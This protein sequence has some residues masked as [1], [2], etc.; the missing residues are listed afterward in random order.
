MSVRTWSVPAENWI[1]LCTQRAYQ[2]EMASRLHCWSGNTT[3][4]YFRGYLCGWGK[5][6]PPW[7]GTSREC[8]QWNALLWGAH[9]LNRPQQVNLPATIPSPALARALSTSFGPCRVLPLGWLA[10]T[11]QAF[12]GHWLFYWQRRCKDLFP[13]TGRKQS[14]DLCKSWEEVGYAQSQRHRALLW[15]QPSPNELLPHPAGCWCG[16]TANHS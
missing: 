2:S 10:G 3:Y 12:L 6:F 14:Q 7:E 5:S 8:A 4:F 1:L 11:K 13:F 9:L 15:R 16:W